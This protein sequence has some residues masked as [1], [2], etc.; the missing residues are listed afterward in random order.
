VFA[1]GVGE[2]SVVEHGGPQGAH[3]PTEHLGLLAQPL[4]DRF[5]DLVG[6]L[7]LFHQLLGGSPAQQVAEP[8]AG[9]VDVVVE[10]REL[11]HGPVVQVMGDPCALVLG[12][13]EDPAE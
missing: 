5:Q 6:A 13:L 3:Q 2:A 9:A 7:K 12:G 4:L 10:D 11:L 1:Q 8:L